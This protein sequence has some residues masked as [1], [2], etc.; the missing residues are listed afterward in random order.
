MLLIQL[1]LAI[2]NGGKWLGY[3]C[4]KG[5]VLYINLELNEI[6]FTRRVFRV[7]DATG[8]DNPDNAFQVWNL[9]GER[10]RPLDEF[11]EK[12]IG[13]VEGQGFDLVVV[14]PFYK[15]SD[16]IENAAEDVAESLLRI[17]AVAEASGAS[18]VYAHHHAK[19]SQASRSVLDRGSGSGVFARD[20]DVLLDLIELGPGTA[21]DA[22]L[23]QLI[24]KDGAVDDALAL[25]RKAP[26]W[27]AWRLQGI[28]RN[29][30]TPPTRNIWFDYPLHIVDDGLLNDARVMVPGGDDAR[31][32][33]Y[34]TKRH[35][36][37]K[38]IIDAYE[39]YVVEHGEDPTANDLAEILG[40]PA[41]T[42][43][44]HLKVAGFDSYKKGSEKALRYRQ[45][46]T[47]A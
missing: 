42:V 40:T 31:E 13:R 14:D 27:T 1:A 39:Q 17:D 26:S 30:P 37:S 16:G 20:V 15:L 7:L 47:N 11:T 28:S 23:N 33:K 32:G 3:Q 38:R 29:L 2:A 18:V 19:G 35:E 34:E 8:Q 12:L 10:I 9:R 22:R 4:N 45:G 24:D 36:N 25:T 46:Y 41:R 6:E 21:R 5:R 43:K 44:D